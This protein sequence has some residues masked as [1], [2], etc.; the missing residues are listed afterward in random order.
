MVWVPGFISHVELNWESY[1]GLPGFFAHLFERL[2]R[3]VRVV[4]FDKRG[5]GLSDHAAPFGSF[6]DRMDDIGAVM[7][8]E[9]IE[10]AVV[11]GISE[12]GPLALLFAAT[13]PRRVDKLALYGTFAR[14]SRSDDYPI[15]RVEEVESLARFIE[16]TWGTGDALGPFASHAPDPDLARSVMARFERYTATPQTAAHIMR[17]IGEIDVRHVLGSV[18]APVLVVHVARD[19]IVPVEFGRYLAEHLPTLERYAE[20]DGDVHSS[21]RVEDCDLV[22]DELEAFI[23]GAVTS[24]ASLTERVLTTVLFTDIVDSTAWVEKLGDTEWRRRLDAHDAVANEEVARH[25]GRVVKATG[26]GILASFDGPA[27]AVRCAQ[28]L[29]ARARSLG[30]EIRAGVHVGEC[31]IRGD[32]LA[33]IAVHIAARVMSLAEPG[34]VLTTRTVKDLAL[35]SGVE[36]TDRG[37]HHLKGVADE[38]AVLSA[39]G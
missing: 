3:F 19:P 25:R 28:E 1:W 10:R 12:G 9:G 17:Q 36:F 13:Y 39:R 24:R 16:S 35:G 23:R 27:R 33:G 5:T 34:E 30:L 8:A 14:M 7:D 20:L 15:G 11:G 38:V 31:E 18:Q 37:A 6:E 26:D 2:S 29:T 32:D 22:A 21:W 4:T